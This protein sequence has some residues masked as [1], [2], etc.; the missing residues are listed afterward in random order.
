MG[1]WGYRH[2]S[3]LVLLV[4][5]CSVSLRPVKTSSCISEEDKQFV[6]VVSTPGPLGLRLSNTLEILEFVA[7]G[8]GRSRDVEASGLAEISDRLIAVNDRVVTSLSFEEALNE[9]QHAD[10]PKKLRFQSHDGRCLTPPETTITSSGTV[11]PSTVKTST[12]SYD[13]VVSA[14]VTCVS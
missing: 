1:I 10:L 6:V 9:L 11:I 3:W 7:D 2:C 13:Y 4:V 5:A 8:E 14:V 12:K